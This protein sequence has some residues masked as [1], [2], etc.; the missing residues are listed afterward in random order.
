MRDY[1]DQAQVGLG[2]Y[3]TRIFIVNFSLKMWASLFYGLALT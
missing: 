1:Q 3:L 2:T